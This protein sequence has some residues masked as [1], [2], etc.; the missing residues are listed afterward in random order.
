[1]PHLSPEV[2]ARLR[3]HV[4]LFTHDRAGQRFIGLRAAT[5][6]LEQHGLGWADMLTAAFGNGAPEPEVPAERQR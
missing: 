5:E 6:L 3:Q 2:L 1:M 4:G